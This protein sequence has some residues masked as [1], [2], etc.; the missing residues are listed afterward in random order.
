VESKPNVAILLA[1]FQPLPF[2]Q[3]QIKSLLSQQDVNITIFWGDDGST[4]QDVLAVEKLLVGVNY[5]KFS[6][7][8]I[9]AS[10][11]FI[12]LLQAANGFEYYAFCDQDD[13]WDSRKLITQ[14]YYLS[15][16][17]SIIKGVHSHPNILKGNQISQQKVKC[18]SNNPVLLSISNCSKGC[19]L[20]FNNSARDAILESI[21]VDITWHDWWFSLVVA[22][23][24]ELIKSS[25]QLMTYRLHKNNQIGERNIIV[26]A[27]RIV[28]GQKGLRLRQ[29]NNLIAIH[30][31]AM[32]GS[33]LMEYNKVINS[34]SERGLKL[35]LM[36]LGIGRIKNSIFEDSLFKLRCYFFT[37]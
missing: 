23:R 12:R 5:F 15:K 36:L 27:S 18:L 33:L 29:L 26:K 20:M 21:P 19:T 24:G 2:I 6:F 10:K 3:E 25:D 30:G 4:S 8:R 31:P 35:I 34:Y 14:I 17:G 37:P 22:S 7:N 28:V 32:N 9:G 13:I 16:S 1:T 11:N